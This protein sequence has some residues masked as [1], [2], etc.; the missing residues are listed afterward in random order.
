[1]LVP[2]RRVT[3]GRLGPACHRPDR[4][5]HRRPGEGVARRS[6][7]HGYR[8]SNLT[9]IERCT[10][11]DADLMRKPRLRGSLTSGRL[12]CRYVAGSSLRCRLGYFLRKKSELPLDGRST[13][14]GSDC[15]Y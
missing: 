12:S 14:C 7:R 6:G 13:R 15:N 2:T 5:N 11:P 3:R 1:M 10:C 9:R 4:T 8:T